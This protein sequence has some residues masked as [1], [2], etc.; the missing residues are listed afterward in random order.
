[1]LSIFYASCYAAGVRLEAHLLCIRLYRRADKQDK[2]S[3]A[4]VL[5]TSE[6]KAPPTKKYSN[7][8]PE[9]STLSSIHVGGYAKLFLL[10][11]EKLV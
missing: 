10:Y 11:F 4:R 9:Q 7:V 8:K 5:G 6:L 1:M 2:S 3:R